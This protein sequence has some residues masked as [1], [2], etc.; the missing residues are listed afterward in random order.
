MHPFPHNYH[1]SAS[2]T[3]E[4]DVVLSGAGLPN[5]ASQ[6]PAEFD[7]PGDRWSPESLLMAA[8]ADCFSLSFRAIAGGSKI[9]FN[10]L[11]V[12]VDGVLSKVE[13][14][15]QFTEVKI[16]ASLTVPEGVDAGRAERLLTMAEQTCLVTNSLNVE[17]HLESK[18]AIA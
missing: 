16:N 18:V 3:T 5:I 17:C 9:P 7:G 15:M 14:K 11:D 6:P 4:G 2:T 12:T 10:Q 1:V 13:R 8:I